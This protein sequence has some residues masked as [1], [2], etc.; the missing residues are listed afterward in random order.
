MTISDDSVYL[1]WWRCSVCA[2]DVRHFVRRV[3]LYDDEYLICLS[4]RLAMAMAMAMAMVV[5]LI[6]HSLTSTGPAGG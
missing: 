3:F 5:Y 2:H 6:C 4:L 1:E